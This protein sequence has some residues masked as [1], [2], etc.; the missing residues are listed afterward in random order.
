MLLTGIAL[1]F[2]IIY[3]YSFIHQIFIEHL[4]IGV[5]ILQF[6]RNKVSDLMELN[7]F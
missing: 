5:K 3:I 1:S 6:K 4:C 2:I 7:K